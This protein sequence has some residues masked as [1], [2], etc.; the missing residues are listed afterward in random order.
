[1]IHFTAVG[2]EKKVMKSIPHNFISFQAGKYANLSG[3]KFVLVREVMHHKSKTL[4]RVFWLLQRHS[5]AIPPLFLDYKCLLKFFFIP[6]C[7]SQNSCA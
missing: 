7:H 3:C 6:S 4:R 1:M 2:K 5:K